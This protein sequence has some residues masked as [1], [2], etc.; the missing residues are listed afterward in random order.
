MTL[1]EKLKEGQDKFWE[2]RV[3]VC[4][5][6]KM[7]GLCYCGRRYFLPAPVCRAATDLARYYAVYL[8]AC[9]AKADKRIVR[10]VLDAA[11]MGVQTLRLVDQFV[12]M[13]HGFQAGSQQISPVAWASFGRVGLHSMARI[14]FET[15]EEV[16][17]YYLDRVIGEEI[18][19]MPTTIFHQQGT[20][21]AVQE[22]AQAQQMPRGFIVS[23]SLLFLRDLLAHCGPETEELAFLYA[24]SWEEHRDTDP[25]AWWHARA[26]MLAGPQT[27]SEEAEAA[28]RQLAMSRGF[29]RPAEPP[30]RGFVRVRVRVEEDE[31]PGLL[32]AAAKEHDYADIQEWDEDDYRYYGPYGYWG[33]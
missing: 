4:G 10:N 20:I 26:V 1:A 6:P 24:N 9:E 28:R 17:T 29:T 3:E 22:M 5:G 23:A 32:V 31:R 18:A 7:D 33:D 12:A 2:D 19:C 14:H 27:V 30:K 11:D 16:L 8:P 25:A 21:D 13:G 15:T